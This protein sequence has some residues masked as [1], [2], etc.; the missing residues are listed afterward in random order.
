MTDRT[1]IPF[2]KPALAGHELNNIADAVLVKRHISGGG[3]YSRRC[4]T[5]LEER[6]G[7]HRALLTHSCSGALEMAMLLIDLQPGDEVILPSFTFSSTA[8]AVVLR[9][10]VPVFV[11]VHP[12]TFNIDER[13]IE[14]A[15]TARTKAII[16]VHYAGMPCAMPEIMAIAR[17]HGIPVVEDAAQALLS[18]SSAGMMGAIGDIGCISFHETKNVMAG[19]GGAL[20]VNRPDLVERAECLL[21]K[22]TNR[23]QMLRG[24]VDKYT[25]VDVGSSFL[26]SDLV[27]AFLLAQFDMAEEIIGR[28]RSIH[29]YYSKTLASLTDRV[30]LPPPD[31]A[32]NGNG[33][34]FFLVTRS[35]T[36]RS[37]LIDHLKADAIQAVFHYVP[38]HSSPAG[39]RY[40]RTATPSLPITD[41]AGQCLLRLPVFY[42]LTDSEMERVAQSVLDF[43]H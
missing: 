22:G 14:A 21:E 16:V 19:E 12:E 34:I 28:R 32:T 2:N 6:L 15:I 17:R 37:A 18:R 24:E 13:H 27:A 35:E 38:L 4:A 43:Y 11:D 36:E 3:E 31:A 5:W 8:N 29:Q 9:G 30:Q 20:L 40:G 23:R 1:F 10:G 26:P 7:S 25:W 33:H 41:K 42:S 39:Q